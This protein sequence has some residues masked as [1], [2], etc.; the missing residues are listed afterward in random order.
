[1]QHNNCDQLQA[2]RE[3]STKCCSLMACFGLV[4]KQIVIY[5][6]IDDLNLG[7]SFGN[8]SALEIKKPTGSKTSITCLRVCVRVCMRACVCACVRAT[9]VCET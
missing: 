7:N 9:G 5:N 1:M 6:A 4:P 2:G 8:K 3:Q